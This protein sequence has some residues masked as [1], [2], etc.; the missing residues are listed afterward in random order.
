MEGN[1][2]L[3]WCLKSPQKT[4]ISLK[5]SQNNPI[6][7]EYGPAGAPADWLAPRYSRVGL[8]V[9]APKRPF[10]RRNGAHSGLFGCLYG[11]TVA[12]LL[13]LAHCCA[14]TL[15]EPAQLQWAHA[16]AIVSSS[17]SKEWKQQQQQQQG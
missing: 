16:L 6:W 13:C 8:A 3:K 10:P 15:A 11:G 14:D 4:T 1:G 2:W 12:S 9:E 5:S 7:A 17:S